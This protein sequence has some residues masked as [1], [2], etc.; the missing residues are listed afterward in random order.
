[1]PKIRELLI[2][3]HTHHD[4]GYTHVPEVCMQMHER[5]IYEIISLCEHGE[6]D[7]LHSF[8]WTIEITRPLLDF[9]H[10]ASP[11]W[12]NRL[13]QLV[14]RGRIAV[15]GGYAHMTQLIGHEEYIRFFYPLHEIRGQHHFPVSILQHGDIN[16]LSWGIVPLMQQL[17]LHTLVMALNPD[18]GYPPFEQPSAFFWEGQ[19]GSQ[20][21]VWLSMFYSIANNPWELTAGR[22]DKAIEPVQTMVARLEARQDYPFD[23]AV[24]HTAEDNMLPNDKICAAV[25]QWNSQNLQPPMRI[26]TI[27]EAM[28]RAQLQA[29]GLRVV[30]GEW[31]DWWAHGHSSS[32]YEVGLSRIARAEMRAAEVSRAWVNLNDKIES[33]IELY[34]LPIANWYRVS[35]LPLSRFDWHT[36]MASVQDDLLL[37]AEHTWGTFETVSEPF[38]YFTRTHW[39]LKANFVYRAL[40]EVHNLSREALTDLAASLPPA[41][42]LAVVVINPLSIKRDELVI[43]RT[44]GVNHTVL[45][46]D[47]PPLG[48]KVIA[49]DA[50]KYDELLD[51]EPNNIIEN[52]YYRLTVD[53]TNATITSL[54]DLE[55]GKEWIDNDAIAGLGAVVY[56]APDDHDHPAVQIHRRHFHPSTPGPRFAYT[57]AS[58]TGF[59]KVQRAHFGTIITMQ[60]Q[61]EFL[62][63]IQ[64]EIILHD[65]FKAV[66]VTIMLDK[67]ESY[68][69]EGVY[70]L[71]AFALEPAAFWLET[72]NAVYQAGTEQIP[73]SCHDWYSIQHGIGVSDGENSVLWAAREAPL[74][75]LGDFRTGQWLR[76][77]SITRGHIYSWLMNNLYFTNFKAAQGG[78]MQFS[79]RFSTCSGNVNAAEVR[80]FGEAFGNPPLVRVARIQPAEYE[81]LNIEPETVQVQIMKPAVSENGDFILRLKETA[82]QPTTVKLNWKHPQVVQFVRTDLLELELGEPLFNEDGMFI[83]EMQAHELVTLRGNRAK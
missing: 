7:L 42:D 68:E 59:L 71:F 39:H 54:I 73:N 78:R 45:V 67:K 11:E 72:A 52:E 14:R 27:D 79:Y 48:I 26:T 41:D 43:V 17:G 65:S 38:S 80:A 30:R 16:G 21:L 74:V 37:F 5:S 66:D 76:E 8:R 29:D 70:V 20:V 25:R 31:A 1:M 15:T 6:D 60:A 40:A 56:E 55:T 61:H 81:W 22:I 3:P 50:D 9:L 51:L 83:V 53:P 69:M 35:N 34:D 77:L 36:R 75:Q 10:H 28:N 19:D 82:G 63:F 12:V 58:G 46:G 33:K 24:I 62:P 64:L 57:S 13:H 23:F 44:P 49:W 4:I 32:A 2:I 47:I 18:H